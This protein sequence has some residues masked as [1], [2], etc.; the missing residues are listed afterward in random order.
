MKWRVDSGQPIDE[1]L[2]DSILDKMEEGTFCI[3][4]FK[5][6]CTVFTQICNDTE[7]AAD[8]VEGLDKK[9]QIK[10]D[11][12]PAAW[13]TF[14]DMKFEMGSGVIDSPDLT[15][16]MSADLAVDIFSGQVDATAAYMS[17]DLKVDGII[18][19]AILYR[20]LL[21]LVQDELE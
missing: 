10:I 13:L 12:K 9:F 20:T 2:R 19:D 6:Y 3:E 4:D 11:G 21:E 1:E 17:G 15:F 14:K 7:D 16:D 5:D 18:N 8:E